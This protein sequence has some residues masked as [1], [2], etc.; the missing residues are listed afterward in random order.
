MKRNNRVEQDNNRSSILSCERGE[1][2]GYVIVAEAEVRDM[3]M[4]RISHGIVIFHHPHGS[5]T[6]LFENRCEPTAL[7]S[8]TTLQRI[9]SERS[10]ETI[11]VH[12]GSNSSGSH[13]SHIALETTH[14]ARPRKFRRCK[15]Y[16]CERLPYP[17]STTYGQII[18]YFYTIW[19]AS[20]ECMGRWNETA[21]NTYAEYANE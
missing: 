20:C 17:R 14:I 12:F 6:C 19:V 16:D 11:R 7:S 1:R 15:C 13:K 21:T 10:S 4:H 2:E 8:G 9:Q 18:I 5:R 3:P